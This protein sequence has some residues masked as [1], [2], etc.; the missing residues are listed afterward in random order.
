MSWGEAGAVLGSG[1]WRGQGRPGGSGPAVGDP[2]GGETAVGS[3][4]RDRWI[5]AGANAGGVEA[6]MV[7]LAG[8]RGPWTWILRWRWGGLLGTSQGCGGRDR[9]GDPVVQGQQPG[10][11]G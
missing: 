3:R 11:E 4:G 8:N 10:P 2:T 5:I 7:R 1:V 9:A 6:D